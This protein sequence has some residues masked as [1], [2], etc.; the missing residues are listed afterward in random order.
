MIWNQRIAVAPEQPHNER[1]E[2]RFGTY[3]GGLDSTRLDAVAAHAG[4]GALHQLRSE[5]RWQWFGAIGEEV[6]VG[7]ALVKTGYA[8]QLFVWVFDRQTR[9]MVHDVSMT[10][11]GPLVTVSNAPLRGKVAHFEA[12]GQSFKVVRDVKGVRVDVRF[13]GIDLSLHYPPS[14]I[15]PMTAICPVPGDRTNIT[16]KQAGL[17]VEGIVRAKGQTFSLRAPDALGFLDYS[18]GLLAYETDWLWAIGAGK[19][20]DGKQLSFNLC[21]K[22]NEGLENVV[23]L[24]GRI[25]HVGSVSFVFNPN[26][27]KT[28]WMVKSLDETL[29]LTLHVEG[30]RAED[31]NLGLVQSRYV[32]PIGQ[33]RGHIGGETLVDGV[34]VA[35][36]HLARW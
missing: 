31:V 17:S 16:Q 28:P 2:P 11:P 21:D 24:D 9:Q 30:I 14:H 12:A 15:S 22:F 19:T 27:P 5:K 36:D 26:Q 7:G 4:L 3:E 13:R 32:Q 10:L 8:G 29:E 25:F 20:E 34:G 6:A 35:E 18:H 1:G 33:W 23:W